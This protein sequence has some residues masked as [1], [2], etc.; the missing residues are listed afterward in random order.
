M[1]SRQPCCLQFILSSAPPL[2]HPPRLGTLAKPLI[3]SA[4]LLGVMLSCGLCAAAQ[5]PDS[6]VA[7]PAQGAQTPGAQNVSPPNEPVH[8]GGFVPGHKRPLGDPV[9]IAR[10]KTLFDISCRSC[11]GA[12][13][14]GGDMG[15]PNL[16]RSQVAM[17]DISGELIVPIIQGSRQNMGMP[18]I[19]VNDADAHAVAAYVRSVIETIEEQ[20][21]PPSAGR[22]VPSI[23]IGSAI[24]GKAYFGAK[25]SGCHSVT[26]DF[27][28]IA[29]RMSDPKRLQDAWLA[30]GTRN[31]EEM[32]TGTAATARTVTATA[33]LPSGE[34]VQGKLVRV[35]DFLITIATADGSHRTIRRSGETPKVVIQDPLK[36]HRDL[37]S[38]YT[39]NDI[40]DVTAYL[41]TLK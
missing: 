13:L 33:I 26:G 17:S 40:H 38:Q 4:Y 23:L 9:Q 11:H 27:S 7:H 10:G 2:I 24:E 41:A 35:D 36:I 31:E 15:G 5:T 29:A 28:R 19:G 21:A 39:D 6:T 25:C 20:G 32:P 18:A 3:A 14:R 22:E 12:D 34:T 1:R 16:L 30:G 8:R 37:L